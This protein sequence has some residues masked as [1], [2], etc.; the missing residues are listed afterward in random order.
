MIWDVDPVL[1]TL[2]PLTIKWYGLLFATGF[3]IGTAVMTR[4]Y[5]LEKKPEDDVGSLLIYMMVA[6]IVGARLG[7]CL[8]YEPGYYLANPIEILKVHQGGLASHGGAIGI[9]IG[10]WMYSKRHKKQPFLW[11]LDRIAIPAALAGA[12]I[13]LGNLFNSEIVG[14]PTSVPWGVTF[15][16]LGDDIARHPVQLYESIAYFLIF[17]FLWKLYDQRKG[18][19]RQGEF[20]GLFFM[21]VF[22][23][24]F[25]LE[26]VKTQQAA[27][28]LPLGLSMGQFLSIPVIAVGYWLWSTSKTRPLGKPGRK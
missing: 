26:I 22:S 8:F 23:A 15:A 1:F 5:R 20:I 25:L 10:L 12:L 28:S 24:R 7:H 13:R 17:G 16:R 18:A 11:L 21:L 9:T 14:E 3:L 27:F 6:T 19:I 2:G 4:I